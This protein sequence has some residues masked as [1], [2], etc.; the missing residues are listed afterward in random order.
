MNEFARTTLEPIIKRRLKEIEER[1]NEEGAR[2]DCR[3]SNARSILIDGIAENISVNGDSADSS[4]KMWERAAC[5]LGA[6]AGIG[7]LSAGVGAMFGVKEM[8]KNI[9][10][11]TVTMI[12]GFMI[13]GAVTWPVLIAAIVA[14]VIQA[15]I[16]GSGACDKVVN[17]TAR[18]FS[19]SM[20]ANT[21]ACA[22]QLRAKIE[23]KLNQVVDALEKE[24]SGSIDNIECEVRRKESESKDR[25]CDLAQKKQLLARYENK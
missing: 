2:F 15:A 25:Q 3:I 1:V 7:F 8:V 22:S 24:L 13:V 12:V 20:R 16:T 5:A 10:A 23:N 21:H 19:E 17:V 4:P 9:V 11:Q 14:G 18:K 6:F